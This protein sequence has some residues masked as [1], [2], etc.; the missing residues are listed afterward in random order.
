ME[1]HP[2]QTDLVEQW[3]AGETKAHATII[4]AGNAKT[5]TFGAFVTAHLYLVQESSVPVVGE[6]VTQAVLTLWGRVKRFIELNPDLSCRA[7]ILEGQGSRRG[8]YVP[9]M[10]GHCFPIASKPAG[11]QGLI[12]SIAALEEMSEADMATFGALMNRMGKRPDSKLIGISTPSFTPDNALLAV[13]RGIHSGDPMPGVALT[14]YVS[15]ETD[16][17]DESAWSQANPGLAHGILDIGALR[18]DLALLPEQQFRAYRLCQNPK[19]SQSCWLNATDDTGEEAG[20]A[21]DIWQR[22]ESAHA[23]RDDAPTWV[24]V[25][26]AKSRDHAAAVW[27]QFRDDGRLHA[28]CKVWTPTKDA[29]I[30]LEEIADH[31]RHLCGKFSVKQISFDPSY[32]F[33]ASQLDAEGL[34]M[35]ATPP[36]EARMAPLVGHAYQAIRRN[37]ITHDGD[38]QFTL[39]VLAGKRRYG[40]HGFTIEKRQFSNKCD[41]AIALVLAHGAATGIDGPP[42][43]PD[44]IDIETG[45]AA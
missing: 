8:I 26:V 44:Y 15:S 14:E 3:T 42:Q 43:I 23:F 1:L 33:N 29:D 24:G 7:E 20:D 39:H 41:A 45:Q 11:L 35:L 5:T 27:V 9:S 6:T 32:F 17:R 4:G 30:D 13:Q 31:L 28:K 10:A 18:T 2:Y 21:Y 36:T 37:R 34:P 25:D 16:H 40:A 22:A 12:P 38:E 19:G